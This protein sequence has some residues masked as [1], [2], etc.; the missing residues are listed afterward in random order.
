MMIPA[1]LEKAG[2]TIAVVVLFFQHRVSPLMLGPA[3]I[4]LVFGV[5]FVTAYIKTPADRTEINQ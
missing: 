3:S 4:D 5:L 2:F 1:I